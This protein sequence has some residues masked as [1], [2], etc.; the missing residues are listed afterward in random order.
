MLGRLRAERLLPAGG[1][2][3]KLWDNDAKIGPPVVRN[4]E[5]ASPYS[6]LGVAGEMQSLLGGSI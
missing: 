4:S 5:Y 1:L 2:R 6:S 3:E